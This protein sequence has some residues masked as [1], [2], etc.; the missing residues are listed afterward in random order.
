[1]NPEEFRAHAHELVDWMADYL[2]QIERLPVKPDVVP[3]S[4]FK[5]IPVAP[6]DKGEPFDAV[7]RDF[8]EIVLSGMTHWQHP[9]FFAYFPANTSPPSVLAEMLTATLGAQCMS[10]DVTRRHRT[11]RADDGM[12]AV[13][14]CPR[15]FEVSYRASRHMCAA[16]HVVA[17][18]IQ[19]NQKALC[20]KCASRSTAPP[21]HSSIESGED[22][23]PRQ[24][25]CGRCPSMMA[26]P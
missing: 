2:E 14:A 18:F 4:V 20:R 1:M 9:S 22:C 12:A 7:F 23:R 5:Q 19:I 13:M 15:R 8:R 16:D 26:I 3:G 25:I 11:G 24:G 10:W 21:K 6:P 17:F